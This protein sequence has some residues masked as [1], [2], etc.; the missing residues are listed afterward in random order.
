MTTPLRLT[1]RQARHLWLWTNLLSNTPTGPVDLQEMIWRLGF[2]QIDTIRNVTRAHNHI[3]WTRNQNIRESEI[4]K[5]LRAREIFEHFTH[6]ASLIDMRVL[7]YWRR[8]FDRLGAYAGRSEWYQSGLAQEQIATIRARIEAEGALSTH[9]FD[10]KVEKREMWARPP[11]KKAL[12][13][14]W[15]AGD[16]A[17]CHR[18]NFVKFYDLGDRVFPTH[19]PVPDEY[20]VHWLCENAIDRLSFATTGEVGRFWDAMTAREAKAWCSAAKLIP[21]EIETADGGSYLAHAP[22]D[23][24]QRLANTPAP[25]TRLRILNPFDPAI[26]DRARLEKLFGFDYRNEMF[27]PKDKRRWGY[28]VYPLLEGDRFVGRIELKA[29]RKTGALSVIGFWPEPGVRWGPVRH[30]KLDAELAR[31]GRFASL[32]ATNWQVGR[33]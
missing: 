20:A 8:Q 2:V 19:D 23:V 1:N 9:A 13:Q 11:H 6:D 24:E 32:S 14:M 31:F 5:R 7:P 21:V 29:D 4:W 10:T 30:K 16:L 22:A 12:D 33:G 28:Y 27:V 15:Y 25:T 3:L 26:R 18:E 17:T